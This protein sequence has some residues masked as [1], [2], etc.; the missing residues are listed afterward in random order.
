M[1]ETYNKGNHVQ[2]QM[3]FIEEKT[4]LPAPILRPYQTEIK[5]LL[6]A[7]IEQKRDCRVIAQLPTGCG[8]TVVFADF[9][10]EFGKRALILAHREELLTQAAEKVASCGIPRNDID[11]ILQSRPNPNAR[12]WIASIQTLIR[13]E[14]FKAIN[15]ELFVIDECHHSCAA[16][17]KGLMDYYGG[18]PIIGFTATPT[19]SSRKE[20]KELAELWN[21]IVYQMSVKKAILD[22][23]LANIHCYAVKSGI[24][25]DNVKISM[26]DFAQGEL[27]KKVN[28]KNRNAAAVE[29]YLELGGGKAICFTVDVEHAQSMQAEFAA[30]KVDSHFLC[31]ETDRGARRDMLAKFQAAPITENTVITNCGV[32]TEGFDCPN[33]RQVILARPTASPI[34]YL[35][36]LGRGTRKAPGKDSVI[37]VDIVDNCKKKT[38]C[39]CLKTVFQLRPD[40]EIE[41]DVM[42]QIAQA[43]KSQAQESTEQEKLEIALAN[44]LFDMPEELERSCLAWCSPV[45]Q[46]YTCQITPDSYFKIEDSLMSYKLYRI[47]KGCPPMILQDSTD[48]HEIIDIC[49]DVASQY[50]HT[51]YIWDKSKRINLNNLPVTEKQAKMLQKIAPDINPSMISRDTASQIISGYMAKKTI[52]QGEPATSKQIWFL[53]MSGWYGDG[54]SLTKGQATKLIAEM[55]GGAA[56]STA[57]L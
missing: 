41:G 6:H 12:V 38:L 14:R 55:K 31:G 20:K 16:S 5:A 19:R 56:V 21:K 2:E 24:D 10:R 46:V 44:L 50:P 35:Q 49:E 23:W 51:A 48:I 34:L 36:M 54:K 9:I 37:V 52:S 53:K 25:L 17:Y 39:S 1:C 13:G 43:T 3:N 28:A 29:K 40:I 22:G 27:A 30:A 4:T 42:A 33:I 8:K 57:G 32:L 47:N 11:I 18:I 7:A 45:S 15:P 26:G